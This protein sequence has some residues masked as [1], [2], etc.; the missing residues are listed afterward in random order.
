MGNDP[1]AR[2]CEDLNAV[3]FGPDGGAIMRYA[4]VAHALRAS[5]PP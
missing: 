3:S 1:A 4:D 2:S 5:V